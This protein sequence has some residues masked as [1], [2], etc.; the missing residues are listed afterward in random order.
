MAK[1]AQPET[2]G[3]FSKNLARL[4]E[5]INKDF[6]MEVVIAGSGATLSDVKIWVPTSSVMLNY[7]L[8]GGVPVGR[9]LE[10]FGDP[11]HGKSTLVEHMMIGFQ[12]YPGI[13]I[14]LDSESTWSRP[15]AMAMGHDPDRHLS[16]ECDTIELGFTVAKKTILKAR[17]PESKFPPEMPIG[18]FWDTVS[19]SQTENEKANDIYKEGMADKARKIRA[20]CRDFS[21]FLPRMNASLIFVSQTIADIKS[22]IPGQKK[23][24][25]GGEAIK[26]WSSKRLKTWVSGK[27]EYPFKGAGVICNV[28]TIKDK[29]HPPRKRIEV[30][31]LY[32]T[33]IHNG[34]ELLTYLIDNSDLA[35][36]SGGRVHIPD[37]PIEGEEI[38]FYM[39][40]LPAIMEK[41]PD[42]IAHFRACA[43]K[44]WH[45][46]ETKPPQKDDEEAE[47]D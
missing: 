28:E 11:S 2:G 24:A 8:G 43:D 13:S 10:I 27:F 44:I 37:F 17:A 9:I 21:F 45:G 20:A 26:F 32:A 35:E 18:I 7:L 40:Q 3:D 19:A 15:R 5:S 36:M 31:V 4:A 39:K 34:Y 47:E 6:K 29:I 42:L 14:L 1:K 23:S 38:T 22:P 46:V 16:F 12:R 25:S 41:Y 33:G 30:P